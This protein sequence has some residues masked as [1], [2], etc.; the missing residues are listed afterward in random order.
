MKLL[1]KYIEELYTALDIIAHFES[2]DSRELKQAIRKEI[3]R[4]EVLIEAGQVRA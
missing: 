1:T 2:G 4:I 3:D